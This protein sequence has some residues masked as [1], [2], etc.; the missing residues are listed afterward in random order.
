MNASTEHPYLDKV[1]KKVQYN[2]LTKVYL[3]NK[4]YFLNKTRPEKKKS[5]FFKIL[6]NVVVC[7]V[8]RKGLEKL[9]PTTPRLPSAKTEGVSQ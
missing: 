3:L 2:V 4:E 5:L 8:A 9:F 7:W 6:L 1:I